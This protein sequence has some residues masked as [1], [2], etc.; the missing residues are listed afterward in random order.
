MRRHLAGAG[1]TIL[2]VEQDAALAG[3]VAE[4]LAARGYEVRRA[5]SGA[6]A[7]AILAESAPDLV[8]LDLLLP[9]VD[10][11]VLCAELVERADVPVIV[12]SDSEQKTERILSLKLG[13]EDVI[14]KPFDP[15]ELAAHVAAVLTRAGRLRA[16]DHGRPRAADD[17]LRL[18]RLVVDQAAAEVTLGG[19][20]L[21]LTPTEHRLL[22]ALMSHPN[23]VL[24]RADLGQVIWDSPDVQGSRAID[25]QVYRLRAKLNAGPAPAPQIVSVRGFGYKI[26]AAPESERGSPTPIGPPLDR[27]ADAAG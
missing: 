25:T 8:L 23:H 15:D 24:S 5:A 16:V 19:T 9:D 10:G 17:V 21:T 2:I 7:R 11:L 3:L 4:A 1:T 12:C 26:V 27:R 14:T 13:A 20:V 18:G 22:V 6:E